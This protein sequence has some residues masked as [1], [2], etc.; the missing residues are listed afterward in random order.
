MT[1]DRPPRKT[2]AVMAVLLVSIIIFVSPTLV[3]PASAAPNADSTSSTT[4]SASSSGSVS[5]FPVG[6]SPGSGYETEFEYLGA[7]AQ[8]AQIALMKADGVKW[9]RVDVFCGEP[10]TSLISQ[11]EHAGI[12]VDA[13]VTNVCGAQTPA[14]FASAA[15]QAVKTLEPLGVQT[16]EVFNEPNCQGVSAQSY[17]AILKAAYTALVTADPSAF[18]LAGGL[19]PNTGSYE[20]Y[21]YLQAMYADGAKGYFD[22]ANLHPY[23]YPDTPLQTS[24]SWNPWTYLPELHTIMANNGDGSKKIWLTEFGCPTGTAAGLPADC[25]PTTEG[26][27]ITDAFDKASGLTWI[28]GLFVFSWQDDATDGDFGLYTSSGVAKTSALA[29]FK[30]AAGV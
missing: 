15:T 20:P 22:A 10:Y 29:A 4:V 11:A 28:G 26:Q 5:S 2:L 30:A 18:V 1:R 3:S 19:C 25:T 14:D 8:A 16:F 21:T 9:L 17:T 27:Q 13:L 24:A 6:I 23:S 7:S 12:Q